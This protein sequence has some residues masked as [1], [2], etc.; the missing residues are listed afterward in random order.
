[1]KKP[2]TK[3]EKKINTIEDRAYSSVHSIVS[4]VG[5]FAYIIV[6]VV[7][8]K[9]FEQPE[10]QKN[11]ASLMLAVLLLISVVISRVWNNKLR[12]SAETDYKGMKKVC[13]VLERYARGIGYSSHILLAITLIV[14]VVI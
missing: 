5:S 8:R 10:M 4:F 3:K 1:M 6:D 7:C 2:R 12:K 14:S 11:I 9:C 13:S